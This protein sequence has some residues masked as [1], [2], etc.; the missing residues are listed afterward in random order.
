MEAGLVK[1]VCSFADRRRGTSACRRGRR[2]ES[3][4]GN[5]GLRM[6][7]MTVKTRDWGMRYGL[8]SA[9]M[10]DSNEFPAFLHVLDKLL[11]TQFAVS[12]SIFLLVLLNFTIIADIKLFVA[13]SIAAWLR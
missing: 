7:L 12:S 6:K 8:W 11:F 13:R 5:G 10:T 9:T 2:E 4:T 3:E 1:M